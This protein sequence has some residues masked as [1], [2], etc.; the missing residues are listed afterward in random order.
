MVLSNDNNTAHSIYDVTTA[1]YF[2]FDEQPIGTY[3][4]HWNWDGL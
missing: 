2:G 4:G 1:L 3:I